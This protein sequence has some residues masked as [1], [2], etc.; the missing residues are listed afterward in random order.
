[1]GTTQSISATFSEPMN[2]A[3]IIAPGTFT[4]TGPGV[5]PVPGTVTYDPTNDIATFAPIG[6]S[7]ATGTTFTATI[8]TAALSMGLLPLANNYVWTFTTGAGPD[9]TAPQVSSTNPVDMA[10]SVGTNQK[11]VATFDK[12][13][14]S[15]T[16]NGATFTLMGPGVTPVLGTVTYSTIGDTATFTPS[17]AL[18]TS[19]VYTATITTGV[20]DLSGN[21]L[22]SNFVWTFT[23]GLATDTT[24]PTVTLMNP[25]N[26]ALGVG[27]D[28]S[29]NATFDKAMDPSTLNPSTFT[30]TGPGATVVVGKVSY[31]VSGM[32]ATFT[33]VSPLA[34]NITFTATIAGALDLAGNP[35]ATT[36]WTFTTGLTTTG[37]SAVNLGSASSY[38]VLAATTVTAPGAI[39]VN[40]DLGLWPGTSVTGFPPATVNGTINI[41]NPAAMA[42]QADLL[43]AY[44]ILFGLP[45]GATKTGN[46]GGTT[47]T[48]GVYTAPSTSLAVSSGNL[49][50]D[51]QGDTNAVWI[52]QI[53]TTLDVT[54][55]LQVILANGAQAS[56]IFWQV[57]SSA[58]IDTTAVMQGNILA[59]ISVTVNSGATLNGR[60]LAINGAVTAGGS[61]ASLPGCQ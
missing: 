56:N 40:G 53:G 41:N 13:M 15:S 31:D 29:V 33:P 50:L 43:T 54:P 3:S 57:G 58:T 16:I 12:G 26:G 42:A 17:S 6:G 14:N 45:P 61:G 8:S 19:T 11:I 10:L 27:I 18:A 20:S 48:P 23:T 30:V 38:A 52:F 60:A 22:A 36:S 5:T 47:L 25:A 7:F 51:A 24:A 39:V 9:T 28:A 49:T 55:G 37:Q 21:P 59:S 35:L 44:N 2:A 4:V 34:A 32:I 46:I 1:M